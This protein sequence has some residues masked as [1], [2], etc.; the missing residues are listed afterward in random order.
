M[1]KERYVTL[2]YILA[3]LFLTELNTEEQIN[4]NAASNAEK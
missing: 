4:A 3:A 2:W 1:P